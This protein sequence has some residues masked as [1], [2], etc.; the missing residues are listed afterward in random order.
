MDKLLWNEDKRIECEEH[1]DYVIS[2]KT[3]TLSV[4]D[5]ITTIEKHMKQ[6]E[7]DL[8]INL[9]LTQRMFNKDALNKI[10]QGAYI[11]MWYK[12]LLTNPTLLT[13]YTNK[14]VEVDKAEYLYNEYTE[15]LVN[16][17][18]YGNMTH[19]KESEELRYYQQFSMLTRVNRR[20]K[21]TTRD[22]SLAQL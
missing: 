22:T 10:I 11:Q 2:S 14:M 12:A 16:N 15:S 1:I 19:Y 21:K 9:T 3:I 4:G 5:R 17:F 18:V 20:R 6:F 7:E 13:K 8:N